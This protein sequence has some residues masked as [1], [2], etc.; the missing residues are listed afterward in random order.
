LGNVLTTSEVRP[1]PCDGGQIPLNGSAII[2]HR[3]SQ[4]PESRQPTSLHGWVCCQV[5]NWQHVGHL[6]ALIRGPSQ[7]PPTTPPTLSL[8]GDKRL[9]LWHPC[10]RGT[11]SPSFHQGS[12]PPAPHW[13]AHRWC[14]AGTQAPMAHC[15]NH[16]RVPAPP[17]VCPPNAEHSIVT[18]GA[19]QYHAHL[20]MHCGA[21]DCSVWSSHGH[22]SQQR[23]KL[24]Q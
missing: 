16:R 21:G 20:T 15:T 1:C 13:R 17:P 22:G 6:V 18:M 2:Q 9:T 11:S 23:V 3:P 7:P 10:T 12:T 24:G 8:G 19:P 4:P 5:E 14:R